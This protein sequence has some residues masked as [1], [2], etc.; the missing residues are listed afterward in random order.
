MC[1]SRG[2]MS[3]FFPL[4]R[5]LIIGYNQTS[6]SVVI[7]HLGKKIVFFD[8]LILKIITVYIWLTSFFFKYTYFFGSVLKLKLGYDW[9]SIFDIC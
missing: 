6:V 2:H 8:N 1:K 3:H 4:D 7:V 5:L 9:T